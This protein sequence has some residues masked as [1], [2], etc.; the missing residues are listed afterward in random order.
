MKCAAFTQTHGEERILEIQLLS[1]DI[2]CNHIRNTCDLIIFSFHNSSRAFIDECKFLLET[3]F[4][5]DKL[6]FMEFNDISF[7][8]CIENVLDFLIKNDID[9][10]MQ[11]ED[12]TYGIN[13]LE[14]V[15]K[16]DYY[17][18][19][20]IFLKEIKPDYLTLYGDHGTMDFNSNKCIRQYKGNSLQFNCFN[21]SSLHTSQKNNTWFSF[22]AWS[23]IIKAKF[24]RYLFSKMPEDIIN[25]WQIERFVKNVFDN[26]QIEKWGIESTFIRSTNFHGVSINRTMTL[27]DN[28]RRFFQ[29]HPNWN[30]IIKYIETEENKDNIEP[31]LKRK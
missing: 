14:H 23:F 22:C 17:N 11:I 5:K 16:V 28:I 24:Y 13:D 29:E 19:I 18:D 10:F 7:R 20:Q 8:H 3:K 31:I 9:Y 27:Y 15:S 30:T 25:P 21:S 12:D 6:M 1:N 4:D 2:I 26:N